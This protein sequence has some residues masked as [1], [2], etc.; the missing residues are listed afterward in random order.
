MN[1]S[2][3]AFVVGGRAYEVTPKQKHIFVAIGSFDPPTLGLWAQCASSAPNRSL[4][5]VTSSRIRYTKYALMKYSIYLLHSTVPSIQYSVLSALSSVFCVLSLVF[6]V[7]CHRDSLCVLCPAFC[8]LRS[9]FC[10]LCSVS[11][12]CVLC[13]VYCINCTIICVCSKICDL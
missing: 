4:I 7:L 1:H 11:Q 8:V 10:V 6:C 2:Y 3:T 5:L 12:R 13:C 9:V